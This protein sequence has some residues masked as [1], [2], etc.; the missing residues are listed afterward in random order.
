MT[1]DLPDAAA[2]GNLGR[3]LAAALP[4]PF[5]GWTVLLEGELGS[6]KTT[7]ARALLHA[8]G[9]E[10]A[11]PSPTYT[12]V[13]PYDLPQGTVYHIDLYR[14]TDESELAFLGFDDLGDGLRLVEW[15]ERAPALCRTADLRVRLAYEGAGRRAV[16]D[17]LG[18]RAGARFEAELRRAYAAGASA[19]A[20]GWT[21]S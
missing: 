15:P 16:I 20:P 6:G 5:A 4:R 11:V 13:E 7:L 1:F 17:R 19:S 12:L 3:A 9:H 21:V 10:G 8:L 14:L 2:T 18:D